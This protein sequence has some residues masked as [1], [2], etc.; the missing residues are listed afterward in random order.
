MIIYNSN[1]RGYPTAETKSVKVEWVNGYKREAE[2]VPPGTKNALKILSDYVNTAGNIFKKID[3][4]GKLEFKI[5][6]T[7]TEYLAEDEKSRFYN[8]IREGGISG[9]ISVEFK[10]LK[11]GFPF[12]VVDAFIYLKPIVS[13][14]VSGSMVYVKRSDK[15]S[16]AKSGY[17]LVFNPKIDLEVGGTID[18]ET[19]Q[20]LK[21]E[22]EPFAGVSAWG[23]IKY[24]SSLN[25]I[26][27][28]IGIGKPFVGI[29]SEITVGGYSIIPSGEYKK[30]FEDVKFEA[31]FEPIKLK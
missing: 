22:A 27:S 26:N 15:Q 12:K 24:S 21:I 11:Y 3:P 29:R 8:I 19:G 9:Q 17:N 18:I 13:I 6:Y 23:E 25:E 28:N 5:A 7:G 31:D 20:F 10:G 4:S 14:S 1:Q 30:V 16:F 2:V